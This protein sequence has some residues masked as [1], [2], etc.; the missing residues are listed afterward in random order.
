M[1][2]L[3]L[4]HQIPA[5]PSYL[6]AKIWR[7]LQQAGAVPLKQAVYALPQEEEH[8]EIL[9]WIAQEIVTGGGEAMLLEAQ[10][11]TGLD[12]EQV[13]EL[14]R[15]ARRAD[16]EKVLAEARQ[17]RRSW[18]ERQ[19]GSA[20]TTVEFRATLANLRKSLAAIIAID[21]FPIPER[22]QTEIALAELENACRQGGGSG[23][24]TTAT[25][26]DL[27][28]LQG[29]TWVTRA[30]VYVDRL[31]SA[32]YIRRFIDPEATFKF[33]HSAKYAPGPK[34]IRFDLP[35]AEF[36]HEGNLC[37]F[38]VLVARFAAGDPALAR[39]AGLIHD[40]DLH[41]DAFGMPETAGVRA[42]LDGIV[43]TT[44]DDSS[45]ISSGGAIFDSLL[46][47]FQAN[48]KRTIRR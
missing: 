7:R 33:V 16:Y 6:R 22:N 23:S 42:L 19:P 30:N 46:A 38:E 1:H 28:A 45:R 20:A 13:S 11:L 21:F 37:T 43:T 32:W 35:E 44:A 25:T 36:T 31:A 17:L 4:I 34:E 29:C 9:T 10:L 14:F 18:Q 3:L 41:D 48:N 40:I 24:T 47:Y 8:R 5:K 2:W 12:D 27:A 15:Q 39:L 26:P